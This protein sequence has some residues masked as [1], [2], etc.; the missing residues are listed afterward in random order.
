MRHSSNCCEVL[1]KVFCTVS[2]TVPSHIRLCCQNKVNFRHK[3]I[4][5]A[6]ILIRDMEY[7][8]SHRLISFYYFISYNLKIADSAPNK[9]FR[10]WYLSR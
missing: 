5:V 8:W 3:L 1:L 10:F 6:D 9:R 7:N 2:P 4:T